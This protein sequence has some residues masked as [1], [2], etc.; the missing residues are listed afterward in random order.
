MAQ[1]DEDQLGILAAGGILG[2]LIAQP[3]PEEREWLEYR[4]QCMERKKILNHHQILRS[5]P[6]QV[7]GY[8]IESKNLF[9]LGYFRSSAVMSAISVEVAL[10]KKETKF[11]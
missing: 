2:A 3:K 10:R 5:V 7:Q 1:S 6:T 11:L 4:K 9:C 8:L